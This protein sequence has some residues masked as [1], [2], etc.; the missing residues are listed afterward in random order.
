MCSQL[1]EDGFDEVL[2]LPYLMRRPYNCNS[3][4]TRREQLSELSSY[5]YR[6]LARE[7]TLA[8]QDLRRKKTAEAVTH[9]VG[10]RILREWRLAFR[11]RFVQIQ[12]RAFSAFTLR[13]HLNRDTGIRY[14]QQQP[15]ALR[16]AGRGIFGIGRRR[17]DMGD[18]GCSRSA[19]PR[20]PKS[21]D[22]ACNHL[23]TAAL[24]G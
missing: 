8:S 14:Q 7:I 12:A 23:V 3:Q 18:E 10:I 6:S 16:T 5:K 15:G 1:Q 20:D 17:R 4:F 22:D 21:I 2:L 9:V 13:V 11:R 19:D 24:C